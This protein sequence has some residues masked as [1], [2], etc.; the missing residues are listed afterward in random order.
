MHHL[1]PFILDVGVKR[2][3]AVSSFVARLQISSGFKHMC[4]RVHA[5][6]D[7]LVLCLLTCIFLFSG[8]GCCF[9]TLST[10]ISLSAEILPFDLRR[11]LFSFSIAHSN[12]INTRIR[13]HNQIRNV[14]VCPYVARMH[15]FGT[16]SFLFVL[17][18]TWWFLLSLS[19][20]VSLCVVLFS[21]TTL[22]HCMCACACVYVFMF[23]RAFIS[24]LL[25]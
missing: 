3:F 7:A 8:H 15:F 2:S 24:V 9:D 22:T 13:A 16:H 12:F 5:R 25:S 4:V 1:L 18:R 14:C 23:V 6:A 20:S 17:S 19:L 21:R 10:I 11:V